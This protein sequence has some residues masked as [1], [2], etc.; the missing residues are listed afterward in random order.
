[1]PRQTGAY[2]I[3]NREEFEALNVQLCISLDFSTVVYKVPK[4]YITV[5]KEPNM[6]IIMLA[7]TQEKGYVSIITLQP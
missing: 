1:M 3:L 5:P 2:H 4:R 6:P 7:M